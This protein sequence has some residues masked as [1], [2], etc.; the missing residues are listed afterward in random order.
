MCNNPHKIVLK[1]VNTHSQVS[2]ALILIHGFVEN[3]C[4]SG[5][6]TIN[7]GA[8]HHHPL[9]LYPGS[10]FKYLL[11]LSVGPNEIR[12]NYCHSSTTLSI[13]HIPNATDYEVVPLYVVFRNHDG[14]FQSPEGIGKSTAQ[15]ACK[16][17]DVMLQL[18][19][20]VYAEKLQE[21]GRKRKSFRI[22]Q[23][24]SEYFSK[25]PL[26]KALL[27]NEQ[28]LWNQLAGEII[29]TEGEAKVKRRKYVAILGCTRFEVDT[30]EG[31]YDGDNSYETIKRRTR[32]RAAIGGGNLVVFNTG[33]LYT[34]PDAV[35]VVQEAFLNT[36][37]VDMANYVDD[38][39]YR[40]TFGGC[41][42]TNLGSLCHELGHAFDLGHSEEG[43]M[44]RSFDSTERMFLPVNAIEGN[45][46]L[47]KRMMPGSQ[48]MMMMNDKGNNLSNRL[49]RVRT[50][51]SVLRDYLREKECNGLYFTRNC[52]IILDN[53]KWF[54]S[55]M[56]NEL[57]DR[58]DAKKE[59]NVECQVTARQELSREDRPRADDKEEKPILRFCTRSRTVKAAYGLRLVEW[60]AVGSELVKQFWEFP[61]GEK[62]T[63]FKLPAALTEARTI[64]A[65]GARSSRM[66]LFA[67]DGQGNTFKVEV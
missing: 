8:D 17:I 59:M 64:V 25:L 32:A 16:R 36:T 19:Q 58:E 52:L 53:H 54:Q 67:M 11:S 4:A 3:P 14:H 48:D 13:T 22:G 2:T 18:A 51:G 20:L 12:L 45:K 37:P 1:N 55:D 40:R 10:E 47:P 49:T 62:K 35:D 44:G 21:A 29:Q 6:L 60:R 15:I 56:D 9:T 50:S 33:C 61:E 63:D 43:I 34:W 30:D 42:A 26:E 66:V 57:R 38:S 39:N 27:L 31:S 23:S 41:F 28:E 65:N 46:Q 5:E 7:H 24:C